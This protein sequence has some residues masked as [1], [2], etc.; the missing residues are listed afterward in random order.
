MTALPLV[1]DATEVAAALR[2]E[3][4]DVGK[5]VDAGRLHPIELVPGRPV[6]RPEDLLALV[7]E[8]S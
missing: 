7:D 4:A 1:V 6:F 5:L 2:C 8:A 3:V